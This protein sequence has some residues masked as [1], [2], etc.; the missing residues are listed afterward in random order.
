[1]ARKNKNGEASDGLTARMEVRL[2]PNSKARILLNAKRAGLTSSE[3][4]RQLGEDGEITIK[5]IAGVSHFD[6]LVVYELNKSGVNLMQF[7]KKFHSTGHPPPPEF[8]VIVDE[9]RAFLQQLVHI[10]KA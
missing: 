9:H 7:L 10:L 4:L 1:M 2:H 3:Y 5:E 6:A 8:A